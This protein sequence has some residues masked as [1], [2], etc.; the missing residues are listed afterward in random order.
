MN[1]YHLKKL[2]KEAHEIFGMAM[3]RE[4]RGY[5]SNAREVDVYYVGKRSEVTHENRSY[6]GSNVKT[7]TDE[8]EALK[9]LTEIRINYIL[10]RIRKAKG[11]RRKDKINQKI[12][13]Y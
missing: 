3:A 11:E 5:Y 2:R 8:T 9:H 1:T 4:T 6:Y 12:M 13:T 10:D 7:F